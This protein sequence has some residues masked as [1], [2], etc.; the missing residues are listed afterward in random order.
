MS[1]LKSC[2][3]VKKGIESDLVTDIEEKVWEKYIF[4]FGVSICNFL[5]G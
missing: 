1:R 2:N 4:Y 3:F 5:F